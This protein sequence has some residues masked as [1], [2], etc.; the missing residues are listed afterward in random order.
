[1]MPLDRTEREMAKMFKLVMATALS[2]FKLPSEYAIHRLH[3]PWHGVYPA[4]MRA[5]RKLA[6][7]MGV[8]F[9]LQNP[10]QH[11]RI[12]VWYNKD[13]NQ[14][15]FDTVQEMAAWLLSEYNRRKEAKRETQ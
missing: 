9:K 11:P 5:V 12:L 14:I 10:H 6:C 3:V 7:C 15:A 1:M 13:D 2:T 8:R 4:R